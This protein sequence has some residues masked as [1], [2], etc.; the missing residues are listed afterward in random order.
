MHPDVHDLQRWAQRNLDRNLEYKVS[1]ESILAAQD[2]AQLP[3]QDKKRFQRTLE[4]VESDI[5]KLREIAY[6][7]PPEPKYEHGNNIHRIDSSINSSSNSSGI[8]STSATQ[9]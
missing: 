5:V 6:M 3:T 1:L 2:F 9:D 4:I 7:K 8:G